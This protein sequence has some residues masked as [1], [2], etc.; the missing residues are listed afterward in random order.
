LIRIDAVEKTVFEKFE[1]Y[2]GSKQQ[3]EDVNDQNSQEILKNR[4]N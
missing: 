3:K 2:Y 4:C 1:G